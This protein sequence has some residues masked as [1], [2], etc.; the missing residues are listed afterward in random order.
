MAASMGCILAAFYVLR[1]F[2][3]DVQRGQ[4]RHILWLVLGMTSLSQIVGEQ[5]IGRLLAIR[6]TYERQSSGTVLMD[7]GPAP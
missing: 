5:G 3:L 6:T 7:L 2:G 4:P 1:V